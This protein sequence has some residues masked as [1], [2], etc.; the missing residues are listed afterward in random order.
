MQ[1]NE[2]LYSIH[3][4]GDELILLPKK[5]N[6][7]KSVF[8]WLT[9]MDEKP[10]NYLLTFNSFPPFFPHPET[11]KIIILCGEKRK[12]TANKNCPYDLECYSW[13]DVY[14]FDNITETSINKEDLKKSEERIKKLIEEETKYLGGYDNI[15]LGGFSQGACMSIYIGC[16]FEHL[17]GGVICCSGLLYPGIKINE[18]NKKLNLFVSHGDADDQISKKNNI[19]SLKKINDFLNLEVHYYP[20]VGHYIEEKA[21]ANMVE[22]LYKIVK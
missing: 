20:N 6:K 12:I 14:D 2:G 9:G 19:L 15:Y 3:K 1:N 8:I 11:N 5:G 22:F 16:S 7:Y 17:L 13:F 21:L 10:E 18:N 4:T